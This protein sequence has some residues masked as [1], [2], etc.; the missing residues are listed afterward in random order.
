M[1]WHAWIAIACCVVLAC[2]KPEEKH[3]SRPAPPSASICDSVP[4]ADLIR[5]HPIHVILGA[6]DVV[7]GTPAISDSTYADW[8]TFEPEHLVERI[9]AGDVAAAIRRL[10]ATLDA[11]AP[12]VRSRAVN[13]IASWVSASLAIDR[14]QYASPSIE[15]FRQR[16][17]ARARSARGHPRRCDRSHTGR[18]G[19]RHHGVRRIHRNE[20][21]AHPTCFRACPN[22]NAIASWMKSVPKRRTS[23]GAKRHELRRHLCGGAGGLRAH[24]LFRLRPWHAS[25]ST[26]A[27]F[28]PIEHAVALTAVVH[29]LNS[30]FKTALAGRHAD[31]GVVLRFG[32]PAIA[33]AV[34]G[35]WVLVR[36]SG[37]PPVF[38]YHAFGRDLD[39]TAVKLIVGVVLMLFAMIEVVPALRDRSFSTK[40]MPLGGV[41]SGFFGG[42]SGM[43]GALRSAFLARAGLSKEA[44]IGTG[45]VIACLIDFSRLG[46]Y[47]ASLR[48]AEG[49]DYTLLGSGGPGRV[50]GCGD[51]QLSAEKNHHAGHPAHRGGDV[52]WGRARSH[53]RTHLSLAWCMIQPC[54]PSY[55]PF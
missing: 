11:L 8:L 51:R 33:A 28:F 38:T 50:R 18:E 7:E 26:F 45:V 30:L 48:K 46:V 29:F 15:F 47:G 44:F 22:R 41:L 1:R 23:S 35:A 40:Y 19:G 37:I 4:L 49:L 54:E 5:Q 39:V 55:L 17:R 2:S 42:L 25:A 32:L 27:L 10:C 3:A 12:P 20:L 24:V 21:P 36:L 9:P 6:A 43:Q 31:R 52:V 13:G 16:R 14:A 34:F 53:L